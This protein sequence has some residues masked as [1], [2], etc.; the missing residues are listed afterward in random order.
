MK[1]REPLDVALNLRFSESMDQRAKSIMRCVFLAT[2]VVVIVQ[3]KLYYDAQY[4]MNELLTKV[5]F[6]S[7]LASFALFIVPLLCNFRFCRG[8]SISFMLALR[9]KGFSLLMN[10]GLTA[11]FMINLVFHSVCST[12]SNS[13][14]VPAVAGDVSFLIMLL[15]PL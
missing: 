9:W 1:L 6:I 10:F 8:G 12:I 2:V 13:K 5:Y 15:F 4:T 14:Y 7:I 3:S 11:F